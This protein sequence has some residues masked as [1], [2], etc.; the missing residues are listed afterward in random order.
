[1]AIVGLLL[2]RIVVIE[3]AA[4]GNSGVECLTSSIIYIRSEAVPE[5][6]CL[7]HILVMGRIGPDFPFLAWGRGR[8]G[9]ENRREDSILQPPGVHLRVGVV[10]GLLHVAAYVV[11][12]VAVAH[13]GSRRSEIRKHFECAPL[14]EGVAGESELITVA[15]K[16]SPSVVD[17][18]TVGLL[19]LVC[20]LAHLVVE[21]GPVEPEGIA[22]V[23]YIPA[24]HPLLPVEPPKI[25][26]LLLE[27]MDDAVE[28]GI[29]PGLL[30]HTERYGCIVTRFPSRFVNSLILIL[31]LA[32]DI[33]FRTVVILSGTAEIILPESLV[34]ILIRTYS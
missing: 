2:L 5:P 20:R 33:F 10:I 6:D 14:V 12:P 1:M 25:H 31:F 19:A 4:D 24:L 30:A 3:R 26:A 13:V 15:A 32:I 16:T 29:C 34:A 22:Q 8:V 23:L 17:E 11:A 9:L 21:E 7:L 28:I 18:R 27:R